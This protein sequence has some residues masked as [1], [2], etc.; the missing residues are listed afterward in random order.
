LEIRDGEEALIAR[1]E[2]DFVEKT[3][4]L[5]QN[6]ALWTRIRELG[7]AYIAKNCDPSQME[8]RLGAFLQKVS[9]LPT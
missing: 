9:K 5:Y 6:K 4:R 7:L 1:D 8:K 3:V 2:E